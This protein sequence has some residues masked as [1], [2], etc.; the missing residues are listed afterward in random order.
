MRGGQRA[1]GSAGPGIRRGPAGAAYEGKRAA[2]ER[3]SRANAA[4]ERSGW[5]HKLLIVLTLLS[6]GRLGHGS[7]TPQTDSGDNHDFKMTRFS[8]FSLLF[9]MI[10]WLVH[11]KLVVTINLLL[12]RLATSGRTTALGRPTASIPPDCPACLFG[13]RIY[14]RC[15]TLLVGVTSNILKCIHAEDNQSY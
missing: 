3:G 14:Q 15:H 4:A 9:C 2:G 5:R 11:N 10:V 12:S 7:R 1:A 8:K 6:P 13:A